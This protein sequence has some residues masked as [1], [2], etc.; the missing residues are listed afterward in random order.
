MHMAVFCE[1]ERNRIEKIYFKKIYDGSSYEY[2]TAC[3]VFV[4]FCPTSF[5]VFYVS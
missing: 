5:L 1:L 2:T 3:A 4:V